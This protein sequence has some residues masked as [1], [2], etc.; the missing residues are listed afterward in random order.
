M[1]FTAPVGR[2]VL[3]GVQSSSIIPAD[4]SVMAPISSVFKIIE[5]IHLPD[6]DLFRGIKTSQ[7]LPAPAANTPRD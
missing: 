3:I 1:Q 6:A 2:A 4:F 7:P 5:N